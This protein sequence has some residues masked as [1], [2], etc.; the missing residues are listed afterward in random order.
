LEDGDINIT[1]TP[2][3]TRP[4]LLLPVL[5]NILAT[6]KEIE[7][8]VEKTEMRM[9][10]ASL[11]II[12]EGDELAL[13]RALINTVVEEPETAPPESNEYLL[14]SHP[15]VPAT[16]RN[17][18]AYAVKVIDFAHTKIQEG[19]GPD[20]GVLLGLKTTMS[21]LEGRIK[22]VQEVIGSSE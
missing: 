10:A 6:V 4:E 21:L 8:A 1:S 19:L 3:G 2:A 11:L 12:Y 22:E 16:N 14:P 5:R 15:S 9:V 20:E 13:E 17:P 7:E 18:P